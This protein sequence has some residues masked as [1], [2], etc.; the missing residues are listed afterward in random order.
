MAGIMKSKGLQPVRGTDYR[1]PAYGIKPVARFI[2]FAKKQHKAYQVALKAHG[3]NYE[4]LYVLYSYYILLTLNLYNIIISKR[5]CTANRL[6]TF[7]T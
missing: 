4:Q 7:A 3:I 1:H 2:I 6:Y 5:V